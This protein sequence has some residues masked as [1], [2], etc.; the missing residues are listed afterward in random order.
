MYGMPSPSASQA[1]VR[2]SS[3]PMSAMYASEFGST[4]SPSMRVFQGLSVGKMG[5]SCGPGGGG[6]GSGLVGGVGWVPASDPTSGTAVPESPPP[7]ATLDPP[8]RRPGGT[9]RP[10]VPGSSG[11][12]AS[13]SVTPPL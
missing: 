2:G 9:V 8:S 5:A 7:S 13:V 10:G 3:A 12:L 1:A 11:S 6:G 4:G